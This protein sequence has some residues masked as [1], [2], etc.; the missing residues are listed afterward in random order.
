MDVWY[1]IDDFI[2]FFTN[3]LFTDEECLLLGC[4]TMLHHI[5]QDSI[6]RSNPQKSLKSYIVIHS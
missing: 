1:K 5:L 6:I 2:P 3:L 4:E